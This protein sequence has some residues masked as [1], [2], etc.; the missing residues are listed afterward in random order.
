MEANAM[1]ISGALL[2]AAG[3]ILLGTS[4]PGYARSNASP[5]PFRNSSLTG[6]CPATPSP[7]VVLPCEGC[8]VDYMSTFVNSMSCDG[9]CAF[10]WSVDW[11]C[12]TS[13]ANCGGSGRVDCG[14]TKYKYCFC[15]D[16][17]YGKVTFTFICGT[18]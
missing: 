15:P 7:P 6:T 11:T 18:C 5:R 2:G 9:F 13:S 8:D 16:S 4:R 1:Q 10:T 12:P 14:T 3:L 17:I